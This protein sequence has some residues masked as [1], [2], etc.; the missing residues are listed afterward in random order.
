MV[1]DKYGY[2]YGTTMQGG[3]YMGGSVFRLAPDGTLTLL[4]SFGGDSDGGFP[5]AGVVRDS[6]GNLYGT[7]EYGG[8]FHKGTV[9]RLAPD[10][11]LTVLHRFRGPD[12][13]SPASGVVRD[14]RGN[15]YGTTTQGGTADRGTLYL[16]SWKPATP[17]TRPTR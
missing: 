10:G 9:F 14:S 3:A 11:T 8:A 13:R 2:L 16:L 17:A 4:H 12:G 15:L 7:T 5:R 6:F 1:R